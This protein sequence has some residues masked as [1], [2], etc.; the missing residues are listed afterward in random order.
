MVHEVSIDL[1][2]PGCRVLL[3]SDWHFDNPKCRRDLLQ[4]HLDEAVETDSPVMC[5]GDLFCMMQ[6]KY[7]KRSA[8]TDLRPE[9]QTGSY[10]DA[11]IDEAAD[12]LDPYKHVLAFITLGNHETSIID[13]HETNPIDR[14]AA[15]LRD[16][17]GITLSGGYQGY[18]RFNL[19]HGTARHRFRLFFHH[20]AGG[21]APVTKGAID[22]NRL[23]EIAEADI[24][25]LGHI[26]RRNHD[27]G[28]LLDL[29]HNGRLT[30]R[31][32]DYVRTSTYKQEGHHAAGWC[33]SKMMGTRPLGGF[34]M[35]VS[36]RRERKQRIFER[37]FVPTSPNH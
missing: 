3:T 20:G 18:V 13:R 22:F 19:F 21:G 15:K 16:K 35:E 36:Q 31:Q 32:R 25:V 27:D 30:L 6:G 33:E 23:R 5:F 14:L 8:K 26:H 17:G 37:K 7:D 24:Y 4:R 12:W 34:W 28:V 9:H 10:I 29:N 11:V 2:K 1:A